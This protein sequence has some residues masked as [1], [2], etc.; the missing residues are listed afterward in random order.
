MSQEI[1]TRAIGCKLSWWDKIHAYFHSHLNVKARQLHTALRNT[2]RE[3]C[4]IS[5]F[6][7]RIQA[8]I[9]TLSSNGETVTT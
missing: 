3:N 9:D 5:D 1:L 6:L 7:L 2:T 4:S 8:L